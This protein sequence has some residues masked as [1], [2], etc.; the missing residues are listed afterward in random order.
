MS[1]SVL[2]ANHLNRN[3]R[4]PELT[5]IQLALDKVTSTIAKEKLQTNID[6]IK[7]KLENV[8]AK[9]IGSTNKP[10]EVIVRG[11]RT[12]KLFGFIPVKLTHIFD[13]DSEGNLI[14]RNRF[15]DIFFIGEKEGFE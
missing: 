10:L 11:K 4:M 6:A 13:V 9:L 12:E 1:L 14:R 15:I 7:E 3:D 5:G 2:G 8:D